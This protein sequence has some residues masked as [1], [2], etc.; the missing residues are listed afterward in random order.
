MDLEKLVNFLIEKGLALNYT[1]SGDIRTINAFRSD[2]QDT[3][4][5]FDYCKVNNVFTLEKVYCRGK[6][7]LT[8][9]DGLEVTTCANSL[10]I[11]SKTS[12]TC[13]EVIV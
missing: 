11:F 3:L 9:E 10:V 7:E 2:S 8:K 1:D 5:S 4:V 6:W 12:R 13:K